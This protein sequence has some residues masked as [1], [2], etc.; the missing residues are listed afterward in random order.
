[1]YGSGQLADFCDTGRDET[2]KSLPELSFIF[3]LIIIYFPFFR[4][5]VK[6]KN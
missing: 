4:G 1:M 3:V 6:V 2:C 5:V